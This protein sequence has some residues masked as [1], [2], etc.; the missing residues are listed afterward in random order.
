[1]PLD[2]DEVFDVFVEF[3]EMEF[4]LAFE[5][6]VSDVGVF[7]EDFG[8]E[9]ITVGVGSW[10]CKVEPELHIISFILLA[11]VLNDLNLK[12]N[13]LPR[14]RQEK[15]QILPINKYP[16]SFLYL[17]HLLILGIRLNRLKLHPIPKNP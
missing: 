16:L 8:E 2:F 13:I 12:R 15:H 6:Y 1:M 14:N 3:F 5:G 17:W 4:V 10:S 7:W 9:E 11:Y